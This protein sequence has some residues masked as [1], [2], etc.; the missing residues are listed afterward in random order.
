MTRLYA[1][2][3]ATGFLA[4]SALISGC[5]TQTAQ[6]PVAATPP[7]PAA[8]VAEGVGTAGE[9]APA[10]ADLAG[11]QYA[12]APYDGAPYGYY[13][14]VPVYPYA[15]APLYGYSPYPFYGRTRVGF[16][17][18]GGRYYDGDRRY[19]RRGYGRKGHR[20]GRYKGDR[21]KGGEHKGGKR[22]GGKH[23][24]DHARHDGNVNDKSANSRSSK[25]TRMVAAVA[26]TVAPRHVRGNQR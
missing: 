20:H 10:P 7:P 22:R 3:R 23:K 12:P 1:F 6:A 21:H 13:R 15:Y 8:Y 11:Q 24:G 17:V 14:P 5:A 4:A 19:K 9:V 18:F 2:L 26:R 16:S 25:E